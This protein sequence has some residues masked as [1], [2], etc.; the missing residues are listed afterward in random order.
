MLTITLLCLLLALTSAQ[1][2][3]YLYIWTG[4]ELQRRC[5]DFVV[6]I[7]VTLNTTDFGRITGVE[8]TPYRGLEPHHAGI[9][10]NGKVANV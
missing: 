10:N 6:A 3:T 5:N 8:Y 1:N 2:A 9:S 7:N 4:S